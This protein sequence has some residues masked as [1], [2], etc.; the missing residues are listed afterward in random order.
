MDG[1]PHELSGGQRQRAMIARALA[2]S[3]KFIVLDEPV[4]ALDV[5]IQSQILNLLIELQ[6]NLG[7]AYLFITHN[8]AAAVHLSDEVAV[9]YL[10]K[11]VEIAPINEFRRGV[12]HPYSAALLS[13]S[14]R[15]DGEPRCAAIV[16]GGELPDPSN[17]PRG[18]AFHPRC[19]FVKDECREQSPS[20][21]SR[22][23]ATTRHLVACHFA[24][25]LNLGDCG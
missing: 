24:G 9:M 19:P 12:L 2:T 1:Y 23:P 10:G 13:A 22:N 15:A 11:I 16:A 8:L 21:V 6:R 4:S 5:S 3:P 14:P 17:P 20:L 18:C 25:K 7:V